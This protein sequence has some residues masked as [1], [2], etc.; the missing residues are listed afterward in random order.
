MLNIKHIF[1]QSTMT[2]TNPPIFGFTG[3]GN[4]SPHDYYLIFRNE[5]EQTGIPMDSFHAR[6]SF[7]LGLREEY[8]AKVPGITN[9]RDIKDHQLYDPAKLVFYFALIENLEDRRIATNVPKQG[10]KPLHEFYELF[11]SYITG[12]G[13]D[14]NSRQAKYIFYLSLTDEYKVKFPLD[15]L[16]VYPMED[17]LSKLTNTKN[18][19]SN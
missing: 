4:K 17:V 15:M 19:T 6:F 2:N 12:M 7:Y 3:Q 5:L 1:I 9:T 16:E 13:L 8:K 11:K 14:I 18:S 10:D